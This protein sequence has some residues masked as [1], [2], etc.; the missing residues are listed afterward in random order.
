MKSPKQNLLVPVIINIQ[1]TGEETVT[2]LST[3]VTS[4]Q[5]FQY[6]PNSPRGF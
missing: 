4:N 6:T 2:D 5:S 3:L 1:D